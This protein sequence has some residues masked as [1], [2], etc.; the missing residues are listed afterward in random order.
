M[1]PRHAVVSYVLCHVLCVMCAHKLTYIHVPIMQCRFIASSAF[2][3]PP[4]PERDEA[5]DVPNATKF[6][7]WGDKAISTTQTLLEINK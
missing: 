7:E 5:D 2:I 4:N 1:Q 3:N 6:W